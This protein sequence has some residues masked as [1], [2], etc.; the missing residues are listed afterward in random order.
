MNDPNDWKKANSKRESWGTHK[1]K[2]DMDWTHCMQSEPTDEHG[3]VDEI[4]NAICYYDVN[5]ETSNAPNSIELLKAIQ[6][7]IPDDRFKKTYL[8]HKL[9]NN[10]GCLKIGTPLQ[11]ANNIH[12]YLDWLRAT[13]KR[14]WDH[15]G[16]NPMRQMLDFC[17]KGMSLNTSTFLHYDERADR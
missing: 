14:T 13:D 9:Y 11:I 7:G 12:H 6:K 8:P 10:N 2:P 15:R 17:K 1:Y 3:T 5:L 4:F 16:L